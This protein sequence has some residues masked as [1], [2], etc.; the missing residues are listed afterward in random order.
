MKAGAVSQTSASS[1][2]ALGLERILDLETRLARTPVVGRKHRE[3][4]KA[5]GIAATAYRM[6]LDNEQAMAMAAHESIPI[7]LA[8]RAFPSVPATRKSRAAKRSR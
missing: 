8:E 1:E 5:I 7:A 4:V 6:S 2:G 3:L